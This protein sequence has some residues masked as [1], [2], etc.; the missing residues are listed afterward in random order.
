MDGQDM[1]PRARTLAWM[2]SL[3]VAGGKLRMAEGYLLELLAWVA[4]SDLDERDAARAA[5]G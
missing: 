2:T 4:F 1:S 3:A 5:G